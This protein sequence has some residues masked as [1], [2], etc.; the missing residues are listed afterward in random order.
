MAARKPSVISRLIHSP[1]TNLYESDE[2]FS[3]RILGRT[4]L[5]YR[6]GAKSTLVDSELLSSASSSTMAVY[7]NSI[8]RWKSPHQDEI[9]SEE[10]R[11]RIIDNLRK[12]FRSQGN[13]IDVIE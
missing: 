3:I 12:V 9:I 5:T 8:Q 4:G 2:G 7:K 6:E 13:D 1:E 11:N 10:D